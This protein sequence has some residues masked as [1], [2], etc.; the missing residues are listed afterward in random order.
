MLP[1]NRNAVITIQGGGIYGLNLLGQLQAVIE[2]YKYGPLA[3]AGTSAGAVVA[4]L[5]WAGYSPS[6]IRGEFI[7]IARKDDQALLNLLGPFEAPPHPHFDM[8]HLRALRDDLVGLLQGVMAVP[9][10]SKGRLDAIKRFCQKPVKAFATY[11]Q[12][13]DILKRLAPHIKRRGI[14]RGDLLEAKIEAMLRDIATK[15]TS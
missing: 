7:S 3:L 11:R 8:R 1:E 10:P 15:L 14:F 5:L 2:A 4:T 12:A 6:K 13:S 9:E